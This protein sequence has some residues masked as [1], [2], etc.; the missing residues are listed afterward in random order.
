MPAA[1]GAAGVTP[2]DLAELQALDAKINALLPEQYQ[3][4]Y[5]AV[6]PVSMG[7]AGLKFGPDGRVAWDEIWTTFCDLALAGGPPH[8]GALLEPVT[9]EEA[10]GEPETYHRVAEE[11][12]RGIYL[13][14]WLPVLPRLAPGWVG[15][16]CQG[17]AM[18]GWLVRAV[19]AENVSARHAQDTLHVPA[20]PHFRLEKE[21]K[22][23][24]TALAK[25]CHHWTEHMSAGQRA[26]VAGAVTGL[27]PEAAL[28]EPATAAEARAAPDRYRAV[29]ETIAG[30][31]AQTAGLP[32]VPSGA[33][34]WVGA[35][36]A[37]EAMAV[38]LMRAVIAENVLARR[39]KDVLYLPA[40]PAFARGNQAQRVVDTAARARRLWTV[41][42]P[43]PVR[44]EPPR[45]RHPQEG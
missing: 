3:G 27:P 5:E 4:C 24:V 43:E 22:N 38:W 16:R 42:R 13:T 19:V 28:L 2:E 36:C 7:S 45:P 44:S 41:R 23:V 29:L 18:A 26:A 34:G 12:G 39:E 40:A 11:I 15:V 30:G 31:L 20:G 37:D 32:T 25:T 1:L 9:A 6:S 8:R 33:P 17:E 35:R 14:T 21:I 10:L